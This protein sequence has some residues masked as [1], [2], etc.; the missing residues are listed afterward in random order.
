VLLIVS[1]LS[2]FLF[3]TISHSTPLHVGTDPRIELLTTVQLLSGY[4]FLTPYY[5]NYARKV[6]NRF[7]PYSAHQAIQLFRGLSNGNGWSDA[8]PTAM[9]YLSAPPEL[10]EQYPIPPPIYA[11]FRGP[12]N[13]RAFV[14]A[15]RSFAYQTRFM[16]FYND[17]ERHFS[18]LQGDVRQLI[19]NHDPISAVESYYGTRQ[20]SYHLILSPLLHHGGFGPHIGRPGGPYEVYI[21]LGP[22]GANRGRPSYGP[23]PH[24]LELIWHEFSH[25]FAND[26]AGDYSVL[27]L[28]HDTLFPP[29]AKSMQKL[30]YRRWL[31]CANE[32][33][34]RAITARMTS[35]LFS[36]QESSQ[37]LREESA[38][39]FR[40]V[41]ALANRLME[42]EKNRELYPSFAVFYP[43]IVDLF[44]E[45]AHSP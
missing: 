19:G 37:N 10:E 39:G 35:Q 6:F 16:S 8:Y 32:H 28:R 18:E 43:R 45:L 22:T 9:L 12:E 3:S 13:F 31:D 4:P 14:A 44:A 36:P 2:I 24:L 42:Y 21:L 25:A 34:I 40:Y 26:L 38:R 20:L 5:Q 30:G 41:H 7:S 1:C 11:A 17:Q 29:I 23:R 33:V 15:L 27:L